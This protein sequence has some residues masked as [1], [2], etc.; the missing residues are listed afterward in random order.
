LCGQ[1]YQ[2]LWNG[3]RKQLAEFVSNYGVWMVAAF[4]ALESI[5]LPLPAEAALIAAAFF[6]A[7]THEIDIWSL[8]AA[9]IVAAILGE[10][11]GFWIGRRFGHQLLMRY[12]TRVGFTEE[13]IRVGQWLFVRFGGRFVFIARFLPFLRNIAAVLAGTN[14][15]AQHSFYFASAT[16]AAAWIIIYGLSAYSFGGAFANLASPAAA[17]LGLAATLIV[18]ATPVLILRYERSLLVKVEREFPGRSESRRRGAGR[19]HTARVL[20]MN[21]AGQQGRRCV[22]SAVFADAAPQPRIERPAESRLP[23]TVEG[24]GKCS[25]VR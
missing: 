13:R 12:G 22:Q 20:A 1:P 19:V 7:R 21:D 17:V 25:A 5:G 8:I 9:G 4:I 15:M 14:S 18:L 2:Q 16:A 24:D 6:A 23:D 3:R 10:M 11:V